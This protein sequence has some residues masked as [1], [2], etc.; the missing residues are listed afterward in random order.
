MNPAL[1]VVA[2]KVIVPVGAAPELPAAG[3]VD[4]CVSTSTVNEKAVF[5]AIVVGLEVIF[6]VV[7][8]LVTVTVG[9]LVLLALKLG[10]PGY[11]A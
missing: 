7:A 5:A 6:D 9:A 11:A 2:V 8:A 1:V 4:V 3:F 10:S